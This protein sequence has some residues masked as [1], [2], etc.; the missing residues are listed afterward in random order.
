MGS[1][2]GYLLQNMPAKNREEAVLLLPLVLTSFLLR[3]GPIFQSLLAPQLYI[4]IICNSRKTLMCLHNLH[5]LQGLNELFLQVYFR[6]WNIVLSENNHLCLNLKYRSHFY[7]LFICILL[8]KFTRSMQ[9]CQKVLG[10]NCQEKLCQW[11][12]WDGRIGESLERA[13]TLA[14][15]LFL[16]K[17]KLGS[18]NES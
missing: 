6:S 12:R 3:T 1:S 2:Q 8:I 10:F 9:I 18:R 17:K 13:L 14:T 16:L 5:M 4:M 15:M 7:A 11:R